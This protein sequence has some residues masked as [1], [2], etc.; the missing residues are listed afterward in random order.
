MFLTED[1]YLAHYGILRK[2]GRYPWGS[3]ETQSER[4]RTF[5]GTVDDLKN[6]GMSETDIA[7]SF[8]LTTTQLRAAKTIA[9]NEQKQA[10]IGMAKR[11]QDKG[12]SNGAI[13]QR[14][15]LAGESSVRALLAADQKDKA[16]VLTS[17][18]DILKNEVDSKGIIQVGTGVES[19]L[20]VSKEK[21]NASIAILR[22]KGYVTHTVQV[23]QLGTSNKTSV[24]VLA[25]PGTT[26]ADVKNNLDKIQLPGVWTPDGG[27][28]YFN[29]KDFPPVSVDAKRIDIRY[30]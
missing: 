12:Y 7:K 27:R 25:P 1:E 4:N 15:G 19:Y 26:Y 21:L 5:L 14:M 2:S 10:Q 3:G 8:E 24:K 28:S 16:K 29:P 20:G 18:S 17:T 13:A 23:D 30:K 9:R 22:E 11:L 6:K